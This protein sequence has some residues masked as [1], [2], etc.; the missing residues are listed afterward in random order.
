[1]RIPLIAILTGSG[2][3]T[4]EWSTKNTAF[5]RTSVPSARGIRPSPGPSATRQAP[6]DVIDVS[7]WETQSPRVA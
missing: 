5:A 2:L 1:M 6:S 3:R 4:S 7:S